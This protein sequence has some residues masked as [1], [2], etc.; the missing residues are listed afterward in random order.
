[1]KNS[2]VIENINFLDSSTHYQGTMI[3]GF[4]FR[5]IELDRLHLPVN[6]VIC[7]CAILIVARSPVVLMV[8][9]SRT[10]R[11]TRRRVPEH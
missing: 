10:S 1:M 5:V 7:N 6:T 11:V 2:I 4:F 8:L 9:F 3:S